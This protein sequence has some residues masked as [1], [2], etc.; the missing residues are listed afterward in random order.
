[1]FLQAGEAALAGRGAG[2]VTPIAQAG[3]YPAD[4]LQQAIAINL[5]APMLAS[6]CLLYT[7]DAA[8]DQAPV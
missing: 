4:Q 7:S 6:D 8:D 1:M 2:V 5:T 3:H